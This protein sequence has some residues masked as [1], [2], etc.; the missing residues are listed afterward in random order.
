MNNVLSFA[1]FDVR[2]Q[3]IKFPFHSFHSICLLAFVV[4]FCHFA[5]AVCHPPQN[6]ILHTKDK[7]DPCFE[8]ELDEKENHSVSRRKTASPSQ[9]EFAFCLHI[10]CYC[11][12][13]ILIDW[14]GNLNFRHKTTA[15]THIE[16][17]LLLIRPDSIPANQKPGPEISAFLFSSIFFHIQ[18]DT[19]NE[20]NSSD[21]D[22]GYCQLYCF[23]YLLLLIF[24]GFFPR[25]LISIHYF[26]I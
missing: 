9:T 14:N 26:W 21:G 19:Y 13:F 23:I 25:S 7:Q 20:A 2:S 12:Y 5:F 10:F 11:S 1:L 3:D 8:K 24:I 22:G 18:R 17:M 15:Q 6:P 16:Q 4:S